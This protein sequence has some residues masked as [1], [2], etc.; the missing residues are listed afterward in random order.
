VSRPRSTFPL[1]QRG[2]RQVSAAV[3]AE[4]AGASPLTRGCG[5]SSRDFSAGATPP[6][7]AHEEEQPDHVDEVPIP[8]RRLEAEM[9]V[10]REMALDGAPEIHRKEAGADHHVK[11]V[12]AG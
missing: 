2:Q 5:A 11:A 6:V 9:V 10:G 8:G 3:S 7:D 4:T 1:P 12:E